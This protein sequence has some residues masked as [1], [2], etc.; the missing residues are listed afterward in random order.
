MAYPA[1]FD[2]QLPTQAFDRGQVALRILLVLVLYWL[3]NGIIGL[4]WLALPIFAAIL[5][6]QKGAQKYLEEA[7]KGPVTWIKLILG[8][9][10]WAALLSDK[11]P[12][13]S[14]GEVAF[15]VQPNGSPSV[16]QAL[17]RIILAIPHGIV[18]W[19]LS[20]IA[21]VVWLATV[22]TI[23]MNGK[24][25]DWGYNYLRGYLKWYARVL[26]YLASLVDE[27]PPFSF[28]DGD[29]ATMP[30]SSPPAAS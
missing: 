24:Y 1:T 28:S 26:A 4:A 18:L 3:L 16:G 10:T 25:P 17:L 27:Y 14:P 9:W 29:D 13:E 30:A 19:F 5:I 12:L 22:I 15:K 21:A 7:D 8:F 6:S 23:L 11:L 2:V 20:I